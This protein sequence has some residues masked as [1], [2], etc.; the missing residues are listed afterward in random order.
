MPLGFLTIAGVDV[1]VTQARRLED[2]RGGEKVRAVAG[3][4]RSTQTVAKRGWSFVTRPL[5]VPEQT[6]LRAAC[7]DGAYVAVG[8]TAMEFV[9]VG[10]ITCL[11]EIGESEY[12]IDAE[13]DAYGWQAPFALT[14]T[15][16]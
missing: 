9:G 12:V 1:E 5:T 8:G 16:V 3:N 4:L 15:E 14:V 11:V 2:D 7:G 13:D 10:T 6:A